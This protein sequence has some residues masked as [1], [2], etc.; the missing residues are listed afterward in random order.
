MEG[1]IEDSTAPRPTPPPSPQHCPRQPAATSPPAPS[2]VL[3][4][5]RGH[6]CWNVEPDFTVT[7]TPSPWGHLTRFTPSSPTT[8]SAQALQEVF[9]HELRFCSSSVLCKGGVKR[10]RSPLRNSKKHF[11]TGFIW[12]L[13]APVPEVRG[14]K[15]RHQTPTPN[16][17][18]SPASCGPRNKDFYDDSSPEHKRPR[19]SGH[20]AGAALSQPG[21]EPGSHSSR[22]PQAPRDKQL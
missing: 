1:G 2:P 9:R 4:P 7:I 19:D 18:G 22:K 6:P 12:R 10:S 14:C 15:R 3:P 13:K 21:T 20:V 5:L 11:K 17:S 8:G 16:P